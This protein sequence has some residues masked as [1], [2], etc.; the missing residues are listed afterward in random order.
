MNNSLYNFGV[1]CKLT[2]TNHLPSSSWG[3][4]LLEVEIKCQHKCLHFPFAK[5]KISRDEWKTGVMRNNKSGKL[6]EWLFWKN[7]QLVEW[8]VGL[9]RRKIWAQHFKCSPSSGRLFSTWENMDLTSSTLLA[10]E[11]GCWEKFTP[12][13]VGLKNFHSFLHWQNFDHKPLS[14]NNSW[15]MNITSSCSGPWWCIKCTEVFL[16]R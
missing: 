16:R 3:Y 12:F 13:K 15:Y 2:F 4:V 11:W 5:T 14:K 7:G 6:G 1:D 10:E 8:Q 9:G